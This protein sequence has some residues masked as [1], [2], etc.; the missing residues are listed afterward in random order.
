L[1]YPEYLSSARRHN[2]ACRVLKERIELYINDDNSNELSNEKCNRLVLILYYLSGYIIEC[3][4]KYKMLEL[5]GFD[6]TVDINKLECTKLELNYFRDVKIHD[7]TR[8]QEV[9][10]S[11]QPDLSHVSEEHDVQSLLEMW[12]PYVRYEHMVLNYQ[13]VNSLYSHANNFLRQ[14]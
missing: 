12:D 4:L 11:K 5:W 9:L 7:F 8:L 14:M 2:E 13:S 1:K 10:S 6:S 3:S